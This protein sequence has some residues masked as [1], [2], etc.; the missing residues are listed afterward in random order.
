MSYLEL[1]KSQFL[2]L[3]EEM[4][5]LDGKCLGSEDETN[6]DKGD[7]FFSIKVNGFW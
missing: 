1:A 3:K 4:L 7:L 6:Y 5:D 2:D